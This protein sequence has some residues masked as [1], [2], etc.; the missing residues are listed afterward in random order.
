MYEK[1]FSPEE[2][3]R[4]PFHHDADV[5]AHADA[6]V[7]EVQAAMDRGVSPHDPEA[8]ELALSWMQM[9]ERGTGNNPGFLMRMNAI[10]EQEP[11][12]RERSG[13]TPKL[14]TFIERALV[15][16]RLAIFERHLSAD[17]MV[18]MRAKYGKQMYAWPK[19]IAEL[20][21][22]MAN[23]TP[24]EDPHVQQLARRWSELFCGY[25]GADPAAHARIRE[26]YA[27][28]PNLRRGS[29][30]DDGLF[31]YVR[32]AMEHLRKKPH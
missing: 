2:L 15:Q 16:A 20:R 13:V 8:H 28:E 5:Q 12:F 7:R 30:V 1:Y 6:M 21:E 19:L 25:A 23:D 9:V 32:Q 3:E 31:S 10:N 4:L 29:A 17:D 14:Q 26:A 27:S 22:A 11:T 24:A 18:R